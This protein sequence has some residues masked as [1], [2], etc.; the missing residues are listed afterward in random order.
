MLDSDLDWIAEHSLE[1]QQQYAGKWVA[2]YDGHV[3][4]VG[5]TA[6]M[7]ATQAQMTAP[8]GD[9]ILEAVPANTDVI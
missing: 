9:F 5:E 8:L 1:I 7:A 4:G 6:A 2:I 3:I